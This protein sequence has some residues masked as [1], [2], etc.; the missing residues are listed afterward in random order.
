MGKSVSELTYSPTRLDRGSEYIKLMWGIKVRLEE[1]LKI[2]SAF[3]L[4]CFNSSET[5]TGIKRQ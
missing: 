1:E 4:S 5:I 3:S 2:F